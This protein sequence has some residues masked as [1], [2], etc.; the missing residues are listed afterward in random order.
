MRTLWQDLRYGLRMLAKSPGFTTIAVLT[1]ALGI[2]ATTA[3]FSVINAVLLRPLPYKDP[4]RVVM[5]YNTEA[6]T[7]GLRINPS[8]AD[9]VDWKAQNH[10][11]SDMAI[12]DWDIDPV[13]SQGVGQPV[14]LPGLRVSAN[15]F[16]ILGVPP[17]L[18][19]TFLPGEDEPGRDTVA[20]LSYRVWRQEFGADP[21]I[22]GKPIRLDG[23]SY[24][25]I[26]VMPPAFLFIS[27]LSNTDWSKDVAI[28][29]P[30]PFKITPKTLR[31]YHWLAA[32]AR[33][34]PGVSLAQA[35]ANMDAINNALRQAYPSPIEVKGLGVKVQPL[36]RDLVRDVRT[37]LILLL[38]AVALTLLIA[39]INVANLLF[40]RGVRRQ[41][42]IGIRLAVGASRA[43]LIRQ[44]LTESTL[45]SL[46]GGLTGVVLALWGIRLLVPM[47]ASNLPRAETIGVDVRVLGFTLFASLL[48]GLLFGM[49]PAIGGSKPDLNQSLKESGRGSAGESLWGRRLRGLLVVSEIAL[50]LML[51]IGAGL[52]M[53]SFFRLLRVNPGFD[54]RNITTAQLDL[55]RTRYADPTGIGTRGWAKGTKL[56]TLRPSRWIFVRDVLERIQALP[57]VKSAA[58]TDPRPVEGGSTWGIGFT[59][60]GRPKPSQDDTPSAIYRPVTPDYFRTMQIPL[61]AGREFSDTDNQQHSLP[62]VIIDQ[63]VAHHYFPHDNPVG[64]YVR[65]K[66]TQEAEE[67][68]FE[69]VGVV[70]AVRESDWETGE[71]GLAQKPPGSCISPIISSRR[72]TRTGRCILR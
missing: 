28:W 6:R 15:F 71:G 4:D 45:L 67:R 7:P 1:L 52:A 42:E 16:S 8:P 53:N 68:T 23:E 55:V 70:G 13:L 29:L 9:C 56:W 19:R 31:P 12:L 24:K 49:A 22:I 17:L 46:T 58:A 50:S 40:A 14:R 54:A 36:Q 63:E 5:V 72:C 43:R 25:V 59:I 26:G 66:Q 10:V 21:G 51:L 18:G 65:A 33:L 61:L 30:N 57:G 44:L 48:T 35:Q 37:P 3:I 47:S 64:Q 38:V 60:E 2:G 32:I 27:N 39:C 41:K 20:V 34:K 11:F 62:V 69:I